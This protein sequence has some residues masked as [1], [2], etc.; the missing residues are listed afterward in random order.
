MDTLPTGLDVT[1]RFVD[2]RNSLC[3][4]SDDRFGLI[5][6]LCHRTSMCLHPWDCVFSFANR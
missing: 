1:G 4:R 6:T 2:E 3:H 5:H